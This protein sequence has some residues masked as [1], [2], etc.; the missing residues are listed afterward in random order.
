MKMPFTKII[1]FFL[2]VVQAHIVKAQSTDFILLKKNKITKATY[3]V[4]STIQCTIQ[5]GVFINGQIEAIKNDSI[6]IKQ[7]D[8]RQVPTQLGVYILDTVHTYY[9]K[10][11]YKQIKAIG[12][13]GR[14]FN[15]SA[16]GASLMS[17]SIVIA[18]ASGIVALVDN[19]RFS[20]NLLI[21][22]AALGGLGYLLYKNGSKGIIIGKKYALVYVNAISIKK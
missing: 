20:P 1:L 8:V 14:K 11:N 10:I 13:P 7:F 19:K 4:G 12:T 9:F 18:I 3:F 6:I 17:G 15:W 21:G 16:S 2:C 22:G 5:S